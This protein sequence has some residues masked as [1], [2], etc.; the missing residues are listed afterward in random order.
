V[1]SFCEAKNQTN[2]HVCQ[3]VVLSQAEAASTHHD[4]ADDQRH[5]HVE[6]DFDGTHEL[7]DDVDGHLDVRDDLDDDRC[8]VT[9]LGIVALI[10]ANTQNVRD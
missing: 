4:D 6:L 10:C 5:N 9:V 1:A 7:G 3:V 2:T 8:A